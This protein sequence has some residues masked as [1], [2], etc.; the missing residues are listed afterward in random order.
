MIEIIHYRHGEAQPKLDAILSRGWAEDSETVETVRKIIHDVRTLGDEALF[1][2]TQS[3]DGITVSELS[4][5]VEQE[6]ID[7]MARKVPESLTEVVREAIRNIRVFHERQ[8]ERSWTISE[9]DGVELGM[10]VSPIASAGLYVPGGSAAYPSSL[11]MTAVPAQVAGVPRIAVVTPPRCLMSSPLMA[12]TIRELGLHEVYTV[13]GAQAIAA[14][15]FGTK[16]IPRVDKIAGP[17]N[18]YVTTA[19]RLLFGR[20]DIDRI[21]GPSEVVILADDSANSVFVAADMLAQAEH[22]PDA[23]A[24]CVT[25]S[26]RLAGEIARD[27]EVQI[28]T[29]DRKKIAAESLRRY[30]AIVVA[31]SIEAAC[32]L[33]SEMAPEHA[34]VMTNDPGAHAAMITSAG[35]I[36]LGAFSPEA[37]GDYFAG[38][39]HVLPTA[40]TAR[41]ASPL[42]VYD[43]IKRTS[44]IR[45]S[46]PR[47]IATAGRI[48]MFA[49]AEGLSGHARSVQVRVPKYAGK[50]GTGAIS[51]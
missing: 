25:T 34:E 19:K 46:E 22:D 14:L 40:R 15:A 2:Y 44:I 4:V 5:K 35:A 47:L 31:D 48:E 24:V 23:S 3:L 41:Y 16:S 12:V 8:C 26:K 17:G 18:A 13:G 39:N 50:S 49:T 21:A 37:A 45:Y 7:E 6:L 36:F 32:E 10:R 1:F 20:V 28:E 43:F 33:V 51:R 9:E 30:G 11:M 27:L 42:G 29:L 38:P